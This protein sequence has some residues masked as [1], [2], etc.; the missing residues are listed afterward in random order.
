MKPTN[1]KETA[2]GYRP[3]QIT[4][5]QRGYQ[6]Q[7]GTKPAGQNPPTGPA[8]STTVTPPSTASSSQRD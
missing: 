4:A 7:P 1:G 5:V 2:L 8:A 3:S 6:P